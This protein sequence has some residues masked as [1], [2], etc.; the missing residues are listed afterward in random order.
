MVSSGETTGLEVRFELP[1]AIARLPGLQVAVIYR[2][3]DGAFLGGNRYGQTAFRSLEDGAR[4]P[5][6]SP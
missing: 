5:G 6:R 4:P 2:S 1:E 3:P